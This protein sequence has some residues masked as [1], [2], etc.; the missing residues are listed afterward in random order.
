MSN[1][2]SKEERVAFEN[3]LEGFNDALVLSENVA[4]YNGMS[5]AED[6]RSNDVIWRPMPYIAR[7]YD[8]SDQ[9]ANFK[10]YT[11][12]SVPSTVGYRKS[13]PWTMTESELR[14]ALQNDRLGS[15]ARQKIAS[16]INVAVQNVASLYGGITVKRTAAASGF[17][18]V[19]ECE[20]QFNEQGVN[21]GDRYLALGT[22]DYNGMASNLAARQTMTGKPQT[23]YEKAYVGTVASFETYKMDYAYRLAAAAGGG[24]LTIDTQAAASNYWIPVAT[25]TASTGEQSNV[26]NRFQTITISATTNVVAGDCFTIAGVNAVHHIT[27]QDT[28]Q[29]KT[30]RVVSVDSG[31]TMT[32]TPA[33]VSTQGGTTA[34]EEYQNCTVAES[35]TAAITFL[36]TVAAPVNCFWHKDAI[37]LRPA[38]LA[39]PGDAGAAVMRGSSDQGIELTMTKQFDIKT[40]ETFFRLDA[41]WGVTMMQPEMAGIMLFNQT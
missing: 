39:I 11:Q 32:I 28:G 2:F 37:E 33:I 15:S 23:A 5:D 41:R 21:S 13:V 6:E 20:A 27:K 36:N 14:D 4:I 31:T 9:T 12:L 34:E 38:H 30:F 24:G 25:R 8:G 17:D 35:A 29:L 18:D 22:R 3:L 1:E 10:P 19:A 7:S 40:M 16:D 26:D